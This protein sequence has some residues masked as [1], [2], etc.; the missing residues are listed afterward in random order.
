MIHRVR[1]RTGLAMRL[2]DP[3]WLRRRYVQDLASIRQMAAEC[4]V[5][6][7]MVR[8]ALVAAGVPIRPPGPWTGHPLLEDPEFLHDAYIGRGM[9]IMAIAGDLRVSEARVARA[10]DQARIP[11]RPRGGPQRPVTAW[12]FHDEVLAAGCLRHAGSLVALDRSRTGMYCEGGVETV[13]Q[14]R[15]QSLN[16]GLASTEP[17]HPRT[18]TTRP[19]VRSACPRATSVRL[20]QS[21]CGATAVP[22][23]THIRSVRRPRPR[24]HV[25][26]S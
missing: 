9:S 2:D 5:H 1:R 10:L 23:T 15:H 13:R 22:R 7:Y 19:N 20:P 17:T 24:T 6:A 14:V 18:D 16:A 21:D 25:R 4:R 12:Q 3:Q 11:R 26:G 8:D